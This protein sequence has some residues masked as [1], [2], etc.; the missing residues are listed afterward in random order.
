MRGKEGRIKK[1]NCFNNN[2]L[3]NHGNYDRL[4]FQNIFLENASLSLSI[5]MCVHPR[6][7]IFFFRFRVQFH[8]NYIH[9]YDKQVFNYVLQIIQKFNSFAAVI[10]AAFFFVACLPSCIPIIINNP[11]YISLKPKI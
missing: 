1:K 2:V 11:T 5:L 3:M 4:K 7:F 8:E 6:L 10:A 9:P